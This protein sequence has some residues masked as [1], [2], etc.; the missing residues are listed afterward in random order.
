MEATLTGRIER[1]E[2][3]LRRWKLGMTAAIVSAAALLTVEAAL[4]QR[5]SLRSDEGD[6]I[7]IPASAHLAAHDF[8]LIGRDGKPYAR[9]YFK[10]NQPVLEFYN[11]TGQLV[12]SVPPAGGGFQ[13][14]SERA[15]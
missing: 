12:W 15:K 7:Q 8:T 11:L 3:Q 1:L 9:L 2:K 14:V 6:S 10:K 13:P 4:S 5:P